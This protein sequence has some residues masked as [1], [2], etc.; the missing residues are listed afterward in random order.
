[1]SDTALSVPPITIRDRIPQAAIEDVV[2]QIVDLFHPLRII[3][4]GS[5][6]YGK[7]HPESDVDLIVVME[8]KLSETRQAV[9][10]LRSISYLFGLDLIVYTPQ[11]LAQRLEWGDPF[12]REIV[13]R[14]KVLY[15]SPG[16]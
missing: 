2:Q 1:M 13:N 16:D 3:L 11:R 4:F 10:I 6:A 8:T 14:G 9:E 7:P 5:Y 15:E 12:V